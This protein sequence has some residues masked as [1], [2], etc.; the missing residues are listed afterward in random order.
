MKLNHIFRKKKS[1]DQ[2]TY[3]ND[4]NLTN[5]LDATYG[6]PIER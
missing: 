6:H 5:I 4:F 3:T 1:H 2:K